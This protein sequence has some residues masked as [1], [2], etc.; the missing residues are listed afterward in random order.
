MFKIDGNN[1]VNTELIETKI[2]HQIL[3]KITSSNVSS[4][5]KNYLLSELKQTIRNLRETCDWF[6]DE[7]RKRGLWNNSNENH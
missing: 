3:L 4:A 5:E 6:E 7:L 1:V 2:L